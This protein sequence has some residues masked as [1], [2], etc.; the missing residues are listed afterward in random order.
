MKLLKYFSNPRRGAGTF[1]RTRRRRRT[2]RRFERATGYG[3]VVGRIGDRDVLSILSI[4][5]IAYDHIPR[6]TGKTMGIL[7]Y[8][9]KVINNMKFCGS[10]VSCTVYS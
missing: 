10:T 6:Q 4:E 2:S 8:V 3:V 1:G 5:A 7:Y 9:R